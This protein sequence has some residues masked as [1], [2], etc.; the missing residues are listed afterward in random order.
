VKRRKSPTS[1]GGEMNADIS[2]FSAGVQ[3]LANKEELW[4]RTS[5]PVKM[6]E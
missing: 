3:T 5:H 6:P 2:Y 1:I 4:L